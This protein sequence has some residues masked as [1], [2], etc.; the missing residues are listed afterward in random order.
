M[1]LEPIIRDYLLEIKHGGNHASTT[2]STYQYHMNQFLSWLRS[3]GHEEPTVQEFSVSVITRYKY[4][5]DQRGLRPRTIRG[6][7]HPLR[8]VD[9]YML[10]MEIIPKS[11]LISETGKTKVAL[12]KKDG[13]KR[14]TVRDEEVEAL[15]DAAHRLRTPKKRALAGAVLSL[16]CY[17]GLRRSEALD[18]KL[19][20][21]NLD[22]SYIQVDNGKGDKSRRVFFADEAAQYFREWL[23]LRGELTHSY[24]LSYDTRRRVGHEGLTEMIREL[25]ST[26]CV[27]RDNVI[28][29]LTNALNIEPHSL[30]HNC[31]THWMRSGMDIKTIQK[32]L[33]HANIETTS[34]Y[35]HTDEVRQE[36][37][38]NLGSRK[39][40]REVEVKRPRFQRHTLR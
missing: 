2:H 5:L 16:F 11:V 33:G 28:H 38:R 17:G 1:L 37:T 21:V 39:V 12:P 15:F 4:F 3:V 29:P 26:A 20:A 35:L 31:A 27:L 18:L 40:V 22:K 36:E 24:F 8:G 34:I 30:R 7:F 32:Q 6:A 13:A 19:E 14:L 10:R 9:E 25:K 23:A